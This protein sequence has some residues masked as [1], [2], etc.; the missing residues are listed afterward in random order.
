MDL[1]IELILDL[2]F[3]SSMEIIKS[4][5]ISKKIRIPLFVFIILLFLVII[6][7][8]IILGFML[9][10]ESK[11]ISL[12]VILLGIILLILFIIKFKKIYQEKFKSI[13]K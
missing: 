2:L 10:S 12:I 5:K 9:E 7:G 6:I 13:K 3:D 11:L 8:I 1:L 4:E